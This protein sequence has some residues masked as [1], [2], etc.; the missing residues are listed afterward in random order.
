MIDGLKVL[1]RADFAGVIEPFAGRTLDS[2]ALRQLADA[3]ASLARE[4]GYILAT[5]YI[6]QQALVGGMLRVQVDE[7]AIDDIRI[8]GSDDPVIRSQLQNLLNGRPVTLATLQHEVSAGRRSARCLDP[9]GHPIRARG[10]PAAGH[11]CGPMRGA[12]TLPARA[13][14]ATDGEPRPVRGSR[15]GA[16]GLISYANG[17][18]SARDRVDLSFSTTPL[19]PDELAYFSAR[20]SVVV[21]WQRHQ[22]RN[23]SAPIRVPSRA[24]I[25]PTANSW[26]L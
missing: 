17:L 23:Y 18:I 12:R 8:E 22:P 14:V 15:R 5:A 20:Y 2:D 13:L 3:V 19:D 6:P 21:K 26:A 10:G 4:R 9:R 16:A 25:L 1:E 7:G 11:P 24:P